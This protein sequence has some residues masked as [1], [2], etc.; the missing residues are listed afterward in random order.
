MSNSSPHLKVAIVTG[1]A[2]GIGRAIVLRLAKDGFQVVVSDL[3]TQREKM[4]DVVK[5]ATEDNAA[6]KHTYIP[7]DVSQEADVQRLVNETVNMFGRLDCMVANAGIANCDTLADVSIEDFRKIVDV[8]TIGTLICYRTAAAAMIK[9]K[10]ARG[11][12]IIGACSIAG[13]RGS[14]FGAAYCSSKFAIRALTQ[15]A[16]MEYGPAGITINAYAPGPV[17]TEMGR[18]IPDKPPRFNLMGTTPVEY[19]TKH[20]IDASVMKRVA[21]PEEIANLASFLASEKSSFITGQCVSV[22]GGLNFD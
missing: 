13:K 16:A 15:V 14:A 9:C 18:S 21:S 1:A 6:G 3:E 17:D 4:Q 2:Q 10:T 19:L 7:C 20:V 11:G 22:D 8:N 12:R 5:Q